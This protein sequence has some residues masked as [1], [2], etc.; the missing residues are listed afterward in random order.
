M[1]LSEA[2]SST[3]VTKPYSEPIQTVLTTSPNR[4]WKQP[5]PYSICT[6]TKAFSFPSPWGS[7]EE[8]VE[9]WRVSVFKP[10]AKPY[11]EC[12]K[13]SYKTYL[14]PGLKARCPNRKAFQPGFGAYRGLARVLKS[15]SNPQNCRKKEKSLEKATF[16]FCAKLWYAP[17]PGSKEI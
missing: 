1:W 15:P 8:F 14:V 9:N 12:P 6:R 10:Y 17:N 13:F 2:P 11:S 4:T 7:Q 3:R 5:K 16:I